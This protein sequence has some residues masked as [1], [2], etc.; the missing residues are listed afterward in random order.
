MLAVANYLIRNNLYDR[1]FVR[2]WWNWEEYMAVEHPELETSFEGF[3]E[4]LK[5]LYAEFT[6]EYAAKESGKDAQRLEDVARVVSKAGTRLTTHNWRSAASGNS[7][8]WQVA[9][10]LFFVNALL[11]AGAH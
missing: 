11:G 10:K 2:R 4:L 7:G 6:F 5:N 8:G 3:E 1:E 9:R